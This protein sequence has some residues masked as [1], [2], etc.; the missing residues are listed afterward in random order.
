MPNQTCNHVPYLADQRDYDWENDCAADI[1]DVHSA[2]LSGTGWHTCPRHTPLYI[3]DLPKATKAAIV[4][5]RWLRRR[6]ARCDYAPPIT[7]YTRDNPCGKFISASYDSK[8]YDEIDVHRCV[9]HTCPCFT[10]GWDD[11]C[12]SIFHPPP[13]NRCNACDDPDS[14]SCPHRNL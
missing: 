2:L 11:D 6:V 12:G 3:T 4:I 8:V 13:D 1:P 9:K 14:T 10:T 7:P 5:Q